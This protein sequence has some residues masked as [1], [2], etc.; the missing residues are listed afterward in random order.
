MSNRAL[1][2]VMA[3]AFCL[4]VVAGGTACKS[5]PEDSTV[6][7][8]VKSKLAV[9]TTTKASTINVDTKEGVVTLTGTVDT[10]AAKAQ[11]E[12]IAKAT[13]GVKSVTNNLAVRPATATTGPGMPS[14][15]DGN[16]TAIENAIAASLTK[17]GVTGV[18][19]DV[20]NG[21]ATLKGSATRDTMQKA[22]QAANEARPQ[23]KQ[24]MN[25]ITVK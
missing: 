6:T 23:P 20:V 7:A 19:V 12:T 17:A 14:A 10:A 11:A 22:M 9:D 2:S 18:E 15:G 4:M 16:D 3:I 1:R 8:T 5:G 24:V 13:D 25:Q 21:V